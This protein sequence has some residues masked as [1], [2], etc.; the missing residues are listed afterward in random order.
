[1]YNKV[2]ITQVFKHSQQA[3]QIHSFLLWSQVS[4]MVPQSPKHIRFP[5][6]TADMSC[7]DAIYLQREILSLSSESI[8]PLIFLRALH[9]V[10]DFPAVGPHA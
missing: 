10:S 7:V 2:Q 4:G 9:W 3:Q 8:P 5:D 6:L 1:M